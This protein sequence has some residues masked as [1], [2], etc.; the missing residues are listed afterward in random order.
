LLVED[1]LEGRRQLDRRRATQDR[2]DRGGD[3]AHQQGA[4]RAVAR[5]NAGMR[6]LRLVGDRGDAVAYL[7]GC[8]LRALLHEERLHDHGL[9]ASC[10]HS[11]EGVLE[12]GGPIDQHG[13][14]ANAE[15]GSGGAR[16]DATQRR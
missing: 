7:K 15:P 10:D 1:E 4:I 9:D 2:L 13:R 5:E 14:H 16:Q 3:P 11:R 12:S 6:E 8:D